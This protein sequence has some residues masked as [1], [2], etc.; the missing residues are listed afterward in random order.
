MPFRFWYAVSCKPKSDQW[1][2]GLIVE[3]STNLPEL[4]EA[5]WLRPDFP[6]WKDPQ[7]Q[8]LPVH[9]VQ[10]WYPLGHLLTNLCLV[11]C[12]SLVWKCPQRMKREWTNSWWRQNTAAVYR[13]EWGPTVRKSKKGTL[14]WPTVDRFCMKVKGYWKYFGLMRW[15]I[16]QHCT[17]LPWSKSPSPHIFHW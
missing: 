17:P 4:V 12:H 10:C 13:D 11:L 6:C 3:R 7:F 15:H 9:A 2:I 14:W 16:Q 8:I 1:M 5:G